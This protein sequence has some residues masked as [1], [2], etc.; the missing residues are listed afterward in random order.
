MP[1]PLNVALISFSHGHQMDYGRLLADHPATRLKAVADV[2]S[3]SDAARGAAEQFA[4]DRGVPFYAHYEQM[5]EQGSLDAVSVAV[6]P[7]DNPAVVAACIERGIHIM[8]EKPAADDANGLHAM[9][10]AVRQSRC[11]FTCAVPALFA[12]PFQAAIQQI[13]AGAIG[14]P[15]V[16]HFQ[17]LQPRGPQYTLTEDQCRHSRRG[18]LANFGPY[19]LLAF[20]KL[21]QQSTTSVFAR[22]GSLFYEHYK[23]HGV[24]DL[25]LL[26]LTM[27]NSAA[28]TILVGRTTTQ[29]QTRTDC[30]MQVLGSDGVLNIEHGL[31]HGFTVFARDGQRFQTFGRSPGEL[32]VD[33]FV[34][35]I[36]DDR[37]PFISL[38]DV[39]EVFTALDAAYHSA[40]NNQ[41]V[42]LEQVSPYNL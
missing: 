16:A 33:D 7:A 25:A 15:R 42:S 29:T 40:D 6:Q 37:E 4:R 30:K 12:S 41:P 9:A 35:C 27:T 14:E 13:Q 36:Y 39:V 17:F 34:R 8:C 23:T 3:A 2:P 26:S 38:D 19:G 10:D 22:L 20:R 5:L 1:E 31:G 18:E 28:G 11:R 24:E 21:L 32:Y